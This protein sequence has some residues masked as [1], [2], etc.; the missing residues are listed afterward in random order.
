MLKGNI[1]VFANVIAFAHHPEQIIR[2]MGRITIMQADPFH[3][4]NIG[5]AFHQFRQRMAFI[6]IQTVIS[7]ILGDHLKFFH[8]LFHQQANLFLDLFHRYGLVTPRTDRNG[9]IRTGTVTPFGDLQVGVMPGSRQNTV[10]SQFPVVGFTQIV[11]QFFPIELSIETVDFRQLILQVFQEPFGKTSHDK[12]FTDLPFLLGLSQIEYH[13]NRLFL[14]ISDKTAGIHNNDF[15]IN[16]M[17]VM[18]DGIPVRHE[19]AHKLL[20]IHQVL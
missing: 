14:G 20:R 4:R 10:G 8:T 2:E 16:L 13:I 12:Q 18:F 5:D 1:H 7:Q 9:T 19:L 15:T 3:S 11:Q 6:Q 17:G